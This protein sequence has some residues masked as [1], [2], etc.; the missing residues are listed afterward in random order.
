M[1][2]Q[3]NTQSPLA[4]GAQPPDGLP[5]SV[6]GQLVFRLAPN[7]WHPFLQLARLDRP[8]GWWLLLLPCWWG[9]AL[10]SVSQ[11][12]PLRGRD[13]LL[14]FAG[15][16]VM[17]G[18]GSTYNDIVDRDIDAKVLRTRGRPL[19]SRRVTVKAAALF[20]AAQC[21]A[22]LAVLLSFN[23]FT[24]VLGFASL[25]VVALYPF[26]KRLSSWPQ[27][28]LGAA[29]AW[30]ALV[31]WSAALGSLAPAPILLYL[32]AVFWTIGYDTIYALQDIEDDVLAGIGSTARAFGGHIRLGAGCL[33]ALSAVCI[34]ASLLAAGAGL[35]AQGGVVLFAAH[36][37][38]QVTR[39]DPGDG[40][41]ALRLFRSNRDAGLLLFAALAA[42]SL[43]APR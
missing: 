24:I 10:A 38:W 15:A 33:Y 28:V 3:A 18:A 32:G 23:G 19:A 39:I 5:D 35:I 8:A 20:L 27:A 31:G 11:G 4:K 1:P 16:V 29:F 21:L 7:S 34:E 6:R 22:G 14:F 2:V 41:L 40:A 25:V 26:M 17:R 9:S 13:L 30:G 12:A 42:E 36:L 43:V 37:A